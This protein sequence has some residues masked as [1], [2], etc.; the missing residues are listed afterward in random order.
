MHEGSLMYKYPFRRGKPAKKVFVLSEDNKILSWG[1][2]KKKLQSSVDL[3]KVDFVVFGARTTAF[4]RT[5]RV[6]ESRAQC[7]SLVVRGNRTYDIMALNS[8][9]AMYWFL[10]I[11][12]ILQEKMIMAGVRMLY[13]PHLLMFRLIWRLREEAEKKCTT[14]GNV[15]CS[16]IRN[17]LDEDEYQE[18]DQEE[19]KE[20]RGRG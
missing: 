11:Q 15:I 14:L 13:K 5:S 9:Q 2:N 8:Q 7:F 10:G 17:A 4:Q 6:P 1:S 18:E 12:W 19:E 20:E 16:A 3:E